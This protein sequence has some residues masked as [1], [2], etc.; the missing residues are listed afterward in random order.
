MSLFSTDVSFF[1]CFGAFG[2][3]SPYHSVFTS[4]VSFLQLHNAFHLKDKEA[5]YGGHTVRKRSHCI[6]ARH[7]I[8]KNK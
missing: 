6:G 5:S 1:T 8:W 3:L 4:F 2:D 7:Q